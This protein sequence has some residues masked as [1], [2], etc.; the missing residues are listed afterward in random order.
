MLDDVIRHHRRPRDHSRE[1]C[2]KK[3]VRFTNKFAI[4][5]PQISMSSAKGVRYVFTCRHKLQLY[6]HTIAQYRRIYGLILVTKF[7]FR[8]ENNE[9][10]SS[11]KY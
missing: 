8:S 9:H 1:F 7:S 10:P 11:Y 3:G 5:I 2:K 4:K 6:D